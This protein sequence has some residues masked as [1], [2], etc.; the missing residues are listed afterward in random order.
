[1]GVPIT[2]EYWLSSTTDPCP[3]SRVL[4]VSGYIPG[5]LAMR[6][7]GKLADKNLPLVTNGELVFQQ[8]W[9]RNSNVPRTLPTGVTASRSTWVRSYSAAIEEP[10]ILVTCA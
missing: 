6:I 10:L 7:C 5:G 8:N 1:M 3:E 9:V 2:Y 4:V